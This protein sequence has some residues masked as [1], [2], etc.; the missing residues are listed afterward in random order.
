MANILASVVVDKS[1]A[2]LGDS[3]NAQW[4]AA[5]HLANLNITQRLIASL[6][7]DV[8]VV[9]TGVGAV[10]STALV[11]GVIQSVPTGGAGLVR[12]NWNMGLTPGTTVG[13][14]ITFIEMDVLS[15][16]TP[17]WNTET[18]SATVVH[19]MW[20]ERNPT[21]FMVYPQNTGTGYV[22]ITYPSTPADISAL[23]ASIILDN[24]Y[25]PAL[26]HGV[27]YYAY[28][29]DAAHALYAQEMAQYHKNE[30]LTLIGRKDLVE[31]E[32]SPRPVRM[33]TDVTGG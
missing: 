12:L 5:T 9:T 4:A 24:I 17:G 15:K 3:G 8:S 19:Y 29:E 30:M 27:C 16:T 13:A 1:E 23:S 21:K 22:S 33:S 11:A 14:P 18:A 7:P 25:E 10:S 2:L 20:D 6:K 31:K 28:L 26:I 32:N